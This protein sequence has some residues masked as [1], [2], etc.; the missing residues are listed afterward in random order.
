LSSDSWP[1]ARLEEV[2]ELVIGRTPPR[3]D[4]RYWTSDLE[5][6]FCTIADM[7]RDGRIISP[8]REGVTALAEVEGKAKRVPS[9][10]LLMSFKLTLG[11]TGVAGRDLFPNEAIVWIRPKPESN[12]DPEFLRLYLPSYDFSASVGVAVKGQTLNQGSLAA[13]VIPVPPAE[14]QRRIVDLLTNAE[15]A[16]EAAARHEELL[17]RIGVGSRAREIGAAQAETV[18]LHEQV[19]VTMGRQRSPKHQRGSNILPYLRAANVKDA[20]L[21]LDDVLSMNF[22]PGEQVKYRLRDGDTLVTEGCGSLEQIGASARWSGEIDG[23]VCFQ[24]T[25]LRLRAVEGK[26]LPGF[27]FQWARWAFE[28]GAFADVARGNNILHIGARR[29][30]LMPFPLSSHDEQARICRLLDEIDAA[31]DAA[32]AE[33]A[34]L[35]ALMQ[36]LIQEFIYEQHPIPETY[37]CL[38]DDGSPLEREVAVM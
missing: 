25:V 11:R 4:A 38:F 33:V 8:A 17:A 34:R 29:A 20:R 3:G 13:L 28:S 18:P 12:V 2:A 9:G 35:S 37:D 6:P 10:S 32:K 31:H 30:E 1:N 19:D 24:N 21:A 5:R 22:D 23:V 26:T 16:V 27:V 14:E 15:L 36:S 7:G